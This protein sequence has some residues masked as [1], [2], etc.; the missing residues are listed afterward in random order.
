LPGYGQHSIRFAF[1]KQLATLQAASQR[2]L[3]MRA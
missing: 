2:M 1:P 3:Q